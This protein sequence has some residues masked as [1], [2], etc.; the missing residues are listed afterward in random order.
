MNTTKQTAV[1]GERTA[2]RAIKFHESYLKREA[3]ALRRQ[4]RKEARG[5]GFEPIFD[6]G[7]SVGINSEGSPF[8]QIIFSINGST[9]CSNCAI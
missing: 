1:M 4:A 5:S 6:K 8:V 3:N 2:A 9:Q 7:Y